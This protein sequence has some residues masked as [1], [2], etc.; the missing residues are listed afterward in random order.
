MAVRYKILYEFSFIASM[1][2]CKI[3]GL[4][5]AWGRVNALKRAWLKLIVDADS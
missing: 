4:C 5:S 2:I 3:D 1:L